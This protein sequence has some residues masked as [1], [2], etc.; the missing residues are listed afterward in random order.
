MDDM[1]SAARAL[2][3]SASN[4][5]PSPGVPTGLRERRAWQRLERVAAFGLAAFGLFALA[6]SLSMP[7]GSATR[8]GAGFL[9]AL[10]AA[11][12][13]LAALAT[14]V[15]PCAAMEARCDRA[16]SPAIGTLL[17]IGAFVLLLPIVGAAAA[18]A[19]LGAGASIAAGNSMLSDAVRGS[20]LALG[21]LALLVLGLGVPIALLP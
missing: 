14:V 12:L 19:L 2:G 8:M 21:V 11:G 6:L 20:L 16:L 18:S 15:R 3:V 1:A 9:P 13:V 4:A 5:P 7:L 17:A 10:S